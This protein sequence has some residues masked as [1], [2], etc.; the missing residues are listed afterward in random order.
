M[1]YFLFVAIILMIGCQTKEEKAR[2]AIK[3]YLSKTLN[4]F[5]S[6][7]PIEYGSLDSN[8]SAFAETDQYQL[9]KER[10]DYYKKQMNDANE[11]AQN[12]E[13]YDKRKAITL[14]KEAEA[15]ANSA[16]EFNKLILEGLDKF[17]GKFNGYIIRHKFRA[18]NAMGGL[19]LNQKY[20]LLSPKMICYKMQDN[21]AE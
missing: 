1:K 9:L 4:D 2:T 7:E 5:K 20:F 18:K 10:R 3:E 11:R 19:V 21:I 15:N 14:Y 6:Y 8:E 17:K 13:L 12:A 16:G